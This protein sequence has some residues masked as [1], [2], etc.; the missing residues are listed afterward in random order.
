M[1]KVPGCEVSGSQWRIFGDI[2]RLTVVFAAES[3][4]AMGTPGHGVGSVSLGG[5]IH[6]ISP[7]L[8]AE[9]RK[10]GEPPLG[11]STHDR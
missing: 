3:L 10:D 7:P 4:T 11:G 2:S 6:Q 5:V 9:S 1:C 8:R